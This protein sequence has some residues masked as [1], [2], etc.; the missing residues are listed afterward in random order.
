M[1]EPITSISFTDLPQPSMAERG[2]RR[3][4]SFPRCATPS[5]CRDPDEDTLNASRHMSRAPSPSRTVDERDSDFP[6]SQNPTIVAFDSESR[7]ETAPSYRKASHVG[8]LEAGRP[9]AENQPPSYLM[10]NVNKRH[11][12]WI[13]VVCF[14]LSGLVDSLAFNGWG[15]FVC[16]TSTDHLMERSTNIV[17]R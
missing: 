6:L 10:R 11:T 12:D 16:I 15:C 3:S 13:L 8:A 14:M 4:S 17:S 5:P 1:T 2:P 7:P 9:E